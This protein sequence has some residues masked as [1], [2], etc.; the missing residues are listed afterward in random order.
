MRGHSL[1]PTYLL[2]ISQS[3]LQTHSNTLS[4]TELELRV[5]LSIAGQPFS[6]PP[7][8]PSLSDSELPKITT[9]P[10][11]FPPSAA[12]PSHLRAS[13]A[14]HL[15]AHVETSATI[16][17]LE[18]L[19]RKHEREERRNSWDDSLPAVQR[20]NR[21]APNP[22]CKE[23]SPLHQAWIATASA[24]SS[25]SSSPPSYTE[26]GVPPLSPTNSLWSSSSSSS[27][28][29]DNSSSDGE[30]EEAE[31]QVVTTPREEPDDYSY[32]LEEVKSMMGIEVRFDHASDAERGERR[33]LDGLGLGDVCAF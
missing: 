32:S 6:S 12:L 14:S 31:L 10:L 26:S 20:R 4:K 15:S 7:S 5:L 19:A 16:A 1:P 33:P 18:R 27:D 30:D 25:A 29:F 2:F 17:S 9:T 21:T 23:R 13:Y 8:S 11:P 24:L 3:T 28:S 22:V